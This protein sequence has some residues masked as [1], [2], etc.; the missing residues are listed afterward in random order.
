MTET[1]S[2]VFVGPLPPPVHGFSEIGRR[3]LNVLR[4]RHHVATYDLTPRKPLSF[5]LVWARFSLSL[6]RKK[7]LALYVGL[8]GGRRQW[9]DLAFILVARIRNTP[10]FVHHHSFAYLNRSR[11]SAKAIF[12]LLGSAVHVVLCDCMRDQMVEM[13][14]VSTDKVRVLSNAAFLDDIVGPG[15]TSSERASLTVG[16][17]SNITLEKG[18]FEFLSLLAEAEFHGLRL[19]GL[20]AGPVD[21]QI[22]ESFRAILARTPNVRYVGPVYGDEKS[23]FYEDLDVLFFPTR[24]GNEAE[25]VTILEALGHGVPVIAFSRG[26]IASMVPSTAG[27]VFTYSESFISEAI[28][29]LRP[30][31]QDS[32]ALENARHSARK[33]FEVQ[34]SLNAVALDELSDEIAGILP[35]RIGK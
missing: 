10:V 9:I 4:R 11:I 1:A 20:V 8:S 16:F 6:L 18:I 12:R 29:A 24:Y 19:Q 21:P 17:L 5:L 27:A 31:S 23:R 32:A 35:P 22:E 30:L 7:P 13:Y 26:C 33:E 25:P 34:R 15:R 14:G 3:M 28:S 2:I